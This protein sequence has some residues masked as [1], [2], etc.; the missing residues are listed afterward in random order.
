MSLVASILDFINGITYFDLTKV[1]K[2][3]VS[4]DLPERKLVDTGEK[5]ADSLYIKHCK[6]KKSK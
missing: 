4:F 1:L 3:F 6:Q 5:R 2:L